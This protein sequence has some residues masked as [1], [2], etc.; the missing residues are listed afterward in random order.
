MLSFWD[1]PSETNVSL[2][3]WWFIAAC[4]QNNPSC[5]HN[6]TQHSIRQDRQNKIELNRSE[7]RDTLQQYKRKEWK[8]KEQ[9]C[10][11]NNVRP[12]GEYAPLDK[13]TRPLG[14]YAC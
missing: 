3:V 9:H 14:G 2:E 11:N 6:Q 12:L 5:N 4:T 10:R 1:L 8:R 13:K 7:E